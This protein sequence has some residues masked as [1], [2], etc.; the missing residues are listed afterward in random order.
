MKRE[1]EEIYSKY[2]KSI[3]CYLLSMI[4]DSYIAEE[5]TQETFYKALKNI[6]KYDEKYKMFT[7]LCN[8]GKN[9][10]YSMYKKTKR[11]EKLDDDSVDDEKEIIER[12]IDNETNEELLKIV[13]NLEEPDRKSVV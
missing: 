9:T 8:I 1:F 2:Y 7:W 4:K 11:F 13:H 10:Y 5:I 12:I 3:Y 6:N